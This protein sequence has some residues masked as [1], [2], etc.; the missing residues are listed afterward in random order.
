[1]DGIKIRMA[2]ARVNAGLSQAE[3]ASR[4]KVSPTT[5]VHWEN[6][7]ITPK[8]AQFEMFCRLCEISPQYVRVGK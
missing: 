1:M 5:I 6:G 4:M 8:P 7:K 2:A 3:I